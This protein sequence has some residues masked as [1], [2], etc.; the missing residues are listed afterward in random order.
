[1]SNNIPLSLS[2]RQ[3]GLLELY[4]PVGRRDVVEV[5]RRGGGLV[6][7]FNALL[8]VQSEGSSVAGGIRFDEDHQ[9]LEVVARYGRPDY[10]S[11]PASSRMTSS[12]GMTCPLSTASCPAL[13]F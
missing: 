13:I 12:C 6:L 3:L 9:R 7:L 2:L 11:H 5:R 4:R 10:A 1:M 8:D